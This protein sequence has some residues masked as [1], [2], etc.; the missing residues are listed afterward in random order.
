MQRLGLIGGTVFY[1][2]DFFI[3][4][5][6]KV[7]DT[8][9]GKSVVF[10]SD[11][12]VF[13]PRHGIDN[14]DYIMPHKINHPANFSALKSLDVRKVIG[15]NSCGSLKRQIKP[16]TIAVPDD[17]IS[18]F[19]IPSIFQKTLGHAT[20]VIDDETRNTL[21]EAATKVGIDIHDGGIYWQNTG[22]RLET[23]AEIRMIA[24]FADMVGMTLGSEATVACELKLSYG[25]LCSIDNYAHGLIDTPLTEDQIRKAASKNA[26]TMV[27]I[28]RVFVKMN[29]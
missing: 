13:V 9:Y 17:F 6:Y 26:E 21:I 16:G 7:I 8:T 22:P 11:S 20:P 1:G 24:Q 14:K 12:L 19:N 18:F 23:K 4:A 15:I 10:V 5:E 2:Q 25:S 28:V 29:N 3:D 27:E